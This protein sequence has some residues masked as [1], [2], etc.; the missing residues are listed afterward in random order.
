MKLFQFYITSNGMKSI[1]NVNNKSKKPLK[2]HEELNL[3]YNKMDYLKGQIQIKQLAS[4]N[5]LPS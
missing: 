2:L 1:R 3:C 5:Y 4:V